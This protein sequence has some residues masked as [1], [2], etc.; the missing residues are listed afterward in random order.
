MR[1]SK[2]KNFLIHERRLTGSESSYHTVKS[3]PM[4]TTSLEVK[5]P[6]FHSPYN[7][8]ENASHNGEHQKLR[9]S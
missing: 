1:F 4:E 3:Q 8:P 2:K 5:L 6:T 7:A 9:T